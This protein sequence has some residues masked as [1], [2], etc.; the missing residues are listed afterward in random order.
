MMVRSKRT[1][2]DRVV[3]TIDEVQGLKVTKGA[4]GAR[5]KK[6]IVTRE[7]KKQWLDVGAGLGPLSITKQSIELDDAVDAPTAGLAARVP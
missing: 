2:R 6:L 5:V 4:L 7:G 3:G 1:A